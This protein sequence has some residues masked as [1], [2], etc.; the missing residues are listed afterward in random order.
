M[1]SSKKVTVGYRYFLGMHLILCHGPVD[2]L[3]RIVIDKKTAWQGVVVSGPLSINAPELFG[4]ESREGGVSGAVDFESGSPT[5]GKNSYLASKLG[6]TISAYRGVAA[7][8]LRQVYVGINPY[9]KNWAFRVQRIHTR[10]GGEV[11]WY[12]AKSEVVTTAAAGGT[13]SFPSTSAHQTPGYNTFEAHVTL[14]EGESMLVQMLGSADSAYS[15]WASDAEVPVGRKPWRYTLNVSKDGA[16]PTAYYPDE[17]DT[18]EQAALAASGIGPIT[19]T[20]PGTFAVYLW[21][22]DTQAANNRGSATFTI[23]RNSEADM[24]PAHIIRECLTDQDWGMGYLETDVDDASFTAAADRLWSEGFGISILWDRQTAIEDFVKEII[25]HINAALYVDRT[26]GKFVLK[27]VRNDYDPDALLVLGEGQVEKVENFSRPAF[28]D[29]VNMVTVNYWDS[30]S[31]TTASISAQDTALIQMQGAVIGTTIQ[32]PGCTNPTLAS[33]LASRDLTTLS[34]PL[35][36]CTVYADRTAASLNI[37]DVFKLDWPDLLAEPVVMRVMSMAFGDG[38]SNQVK[39]VATED[40]F[41]LPEVAVIVPQDPDWVDPSGVPVAATQRIVTEAPYVALFKEVGK[42]VV[43][44]ALGDSPQAGYVAASAVSPV[45]GAIN[46]TVLEDAGGGYE[47]QGVADFSPHAVLAAPASRTDTVLACV[48][49]GELGLVDAGDFV[50]VGDELMALVSVDPSTNE[51]TVGRGVMD[52]VPVE[53][54]AGDVVYAWDSY[55]YVGQ[56]QYVAGENVDVKLLP[57]TGQGTLD[58]A[59]APADT[60]A[61][62]GRA[63]RPY[64]PGNVKIGGAYWPTTASGTFTVTWAHRN[65]LDQQDVLVP[66]PSGDVTPAPNTRYGLRFLDSSDA[67]IVERTDIGPGTASVVLDY[68]GDVTMELYTIDEVGL[69]WQRHRHV[70]AYTPPGGTVVSTITAT[71][72]TPVDDSTIIDGGEI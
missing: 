34:T 7:A 30:L 17:Y 20:G 46:A 25:R 29:M 65:R 49:V 42:D 43:D 51:V 4:G 9:L 23:G 47:S 26:S 33:R 27:L 59:S 2:R 63:A 67:L 32:Y 8:V 37:G 12:D 70:F 18:P 68:T 64:P 66:F 14:E 31:G 16:A 45:G 6:S 44:A 50:Q 57:V 41:A 36:S 55:A 69:S 40:V 1:G 53:H 24:N 58:E 21:D 19:L 61:M 15:L 72:Y 13:Y 35:L 3:T 39:I 56:T 5:Q 54:A 22:G 10:A 52:T 62:A 48:D 11:Q 28:G 71:A 60:V 38:R